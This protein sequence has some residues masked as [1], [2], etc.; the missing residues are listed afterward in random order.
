M[1][2]EKNTVKRYTTFAVCS[3][4]GDKFGWYVDPIAMMEKVKAITKNRLAGGSK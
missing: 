4:C 2:P 1:K 3:E